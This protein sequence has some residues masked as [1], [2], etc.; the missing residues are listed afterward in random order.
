MVFAHKAEKWWM[1]VRRS[2]MAIRFGPLEI[3]ALAPRGSYQARGFSQDSKLCRLR[4]TSQ[5]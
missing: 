1:S 3:R 4:V 2:G 5:S